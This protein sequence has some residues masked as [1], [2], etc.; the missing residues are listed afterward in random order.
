MTMEKLLIVNGNIPVNGTL[1]KQDLAVSGGKIETAGNLDVHNY[2]GYRIIDAGSKLLLPGGI[3]PHV[4]LALPTPAGNSC[5]DFI[6]GSLAALAG[7]TTTIFD[8]VTPRRGQSLL[9]ALTKRRAEAAESV[10]NC[11]LHAGISEWNSAIAAEILPLADKEGIRSFKAYLAYRESIGID[12]PELEELMK[13][14]SGSGAI[15]M[16]HSED[17]EMISRNRQELVSAGKTRPAYH[18]VSRPAEAEITAIGKVIE[19]AARTGCPAY[20]VHISTRRGAEMVGEAKKSGIRV[21]GETCPQYLLLDDSVY[22]LEKPDNKVLPYIL[23]P[24]IRGKHD[25]EGLWDALTSGAIDVVA[26][27]HCPFNIHGQKDIGIDNFTKIPNGAGGIEHRLALLFTYGV[28]TGC[29]SIERFTEL[30]ST[31]P[32]EIFGLGAC[33]G[34]LV[35]GYNADIVVWDPDYS[36]VISAATHH[37]CCDSDIYEGFQTTGRCVQVVLGGQIIE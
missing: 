23:S 18:A 2:S 36:G 3:D 11:F 37:S 21:Y 22:G 25:Q 5:D 28:K 34:K 8:F 33:K 24:P 7:G 29:I 9:N 14:V 31:N 16:V 17:G 1:E 10:V 6:T 15:V 20:I 19:S 4:H 26:T 32:A 27:D 35:P 12:Y 30:V 13:V